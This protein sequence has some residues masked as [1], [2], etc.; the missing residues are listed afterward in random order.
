[1]FRIGEFSRLGRVSVKTLRYY[2]EIGLFTPCHVDEESG[3]RYYAAAQL[4]LLYRLLALKELGFTLEQI[5]PLMRAGLPAGELRGMLRLRQAEIQAR[6]MEEQ[7]RLRRVEDRLNQIEQEGTM[8][9]YE[10]V[11]KSVE[12]V[13][14]ASV[15]DTIP[16]YMAVGALLNEIYDVLIPQGVQGKGCAA[17]WH[18]DEY[19]ETNVDAE[20]VVFLERPI[21]E[22]GRV[23]MREL[24]SETV[25][26]TLHHGSYTTLEQAYSTLLQW[27]AQNGYRISGTNREIYLHHGEGGQE[28]PNH[29]TEI[30]F[31]VTKA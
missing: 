10:C 26:S 17:L 24:P 29:V 7:E 18:D 6:V 15:R 1:M 19:R 8:S 23:R 25:A 2:D 30:Q 20:A 27:I 13:Q 9:V 22:T 21:Q 16:G 31:P 4:P 28:D 14:V 11:V 12:P 3:Y 5:V